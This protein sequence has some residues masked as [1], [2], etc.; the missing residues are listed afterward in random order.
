MGSGYP[1]DMIPLPRLTPDLASLSTALDDAAPDARVNWSRG[2]SGGQLWALWE[3]A[4]ANPAPL[5]V[6]DLV[7]SDDV[8]VRHVG[9]NSLP[10]FCNFE[11]HLIQRLDGTVQRVQG[12]NHNA[13]WLMRLTGPGHFTVTQE[14][15]EVVLFDY[16][17]LAKSVPDGFPPLGP[18]EGGLRGPVFGGMHDRV[19]RVSTHVT[20]GRAWKHGKATQNTFLLVRQD[21]ND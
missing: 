13:G 9:K 15:E 20:I 2:L 3:L 17:V 18:N 5:S 21:E 1:L 16:T 8:V 10:V 4:E 19:R 6:S 7:P 14:S 11:K 12:F